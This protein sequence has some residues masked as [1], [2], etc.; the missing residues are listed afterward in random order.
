M[1][2]PLY[3]YC[4]IVDNAVLL[5]SL[6]TLVTTIEAKRLTASVG[7]TLSHNEEKTLSQVYFMSGFNLMLVMVVLS[8]TLKAQ[9][10]YF[11]RILEQVNP[12]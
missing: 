4:T 8:L 1:Q 6:P 3:Y 10:F 9:E 5:P 12:G 2:N 7:G 11:P